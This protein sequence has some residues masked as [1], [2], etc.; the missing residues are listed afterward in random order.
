MYSKS[1]RNNVFQQKN[2]YAT[3]I[4]ITLLLSMKDVITFIITD[5][6]LF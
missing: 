1:I 5:K 2:A 4:M 3:S 6:L